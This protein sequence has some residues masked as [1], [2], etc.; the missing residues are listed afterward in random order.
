MYHN[1]AYVAVNLLVVKALSKGLLN[2]VP[3]VGHKT[4]EVVK[5]LAPVL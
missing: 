3:L 5:D 1:N 4:L 2:A